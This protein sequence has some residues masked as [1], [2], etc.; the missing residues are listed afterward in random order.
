M[1]ARSG[2]PI[3]TK[4]RL[5]GFNQVPFTWFMRAGQSIDG[6]GRSEGAKAEMA[7]AVPAAAPRPALAT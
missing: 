2:G 3:E 1:G 7:N 5:R 6:T 4:F